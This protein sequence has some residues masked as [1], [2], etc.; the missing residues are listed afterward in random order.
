MGADEFSGVDLFGDPIMPRS[1][2]RGRPEHVWTLERSN[3]VLLAFARGLSVKQAAA[4]L[5]VSV[6]TLRKHYSS[7]VGKRVEAALRFDVVQLA[8][9]NELAKGGS[10]AAEKELGR[11]LEKARLDALSEEVSRSAQPP[12]TARPGKKEEA[13]MEA[14]NVT[15]RYETPPPPSLLN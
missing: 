9:L 12:R 10:V 15:G 4:V 14:E 1:E 11:R 2:G 6:P 5:G 7:E 13:Q 8:R 3:K